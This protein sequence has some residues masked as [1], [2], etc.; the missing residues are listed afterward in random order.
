[1]YQNWQNTNQGD[2]LLKMPGK[3]D[4]GPVDFKSRV[5]ETRGEVMGIATRDVI[6]APPTTRIIDAVEMMTDCGFRRLPI[7]DAGTHRLRGIVTAR[8]IIDLLGGGDHYNLVRVKHN[9]N[10]IAAINESVRSIM[11]QRVR[12][13]PDSAS[14]AEVTETIVTQKIGGL[15][16]V[17]D[18]E[19][20]VGIVTERDVMKALATEETDVVVE[21]VMSTGLRV[22]GPDTPIGTVTREM[23]AHGFRRLPIVSDDV[24]FGIV[25][26][27]DIMKYLGNGEVFTRLSTG[28]VGEMMA[29]PVRTLVSGDLY[30]TVPDR[31]INDAALKMLQKKVGALPVIE[32][33]KLIGLITEFDLVRAFSQE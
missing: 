27:S 9:G 5:V 4:R 1:M 30:T 16:I 31:N 17:N 6:S 15:P 14:L 33:G 32:D 2:K 18:E 29:L 13:I 11:T 20:V 26:A 21:G 3:L 24:L 23:I 8:D 10:L 22:T 28:D 19:V 25:T 12:T 7:T